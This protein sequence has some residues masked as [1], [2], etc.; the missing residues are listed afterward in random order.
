MAIEKFCLYF[1]DDENKVQELNAL[2]LSIQ[3]STWCVCE[4]RI[5]ALAWCLSAVKAGEL[6]SVATWLSHYVANPNTEI[7]FKSSSNRNNDCRNT[8][9]FC[10]ISNLMLLTIEAKKKRDENTRLSLRK[11]LGYMI[12]KCGTILPLLLQTIHLVQDLAKFITLTE[13]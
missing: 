5:C 11:E 3:F 8:A 7:V 6:I 4:R 12:K 9:T 2:C 13:K 1:S 10:W